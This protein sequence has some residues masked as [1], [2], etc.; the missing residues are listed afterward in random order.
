MHG[1]ICPQQA[2]YEKGDILLG[3]VLLQLC[4]SQ[5]LTSGFQVWQQE[6]L[7]IK[8]SCC[9]CYYFLSEVHVIHTPLIWSC[10]GKEA[11]GQGY[12]EQIHHEQ[13]LRLYFSFFLESEV[14][15]TL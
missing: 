4:W 2:T 13:R 12:E 14:N 15:L 9:P 5:S 1:F 3:L 10:V 11:G 7:P 6:H 8:P